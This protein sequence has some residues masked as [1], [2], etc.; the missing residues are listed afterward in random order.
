[1]LA[2][3]LLCEGGWEGL[4][5]GFP[6]SVVGVRKPLERWLFW[7]EAIGCDSVVLQRERRRISLVFLPAK[8]EDFAG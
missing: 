3:G 8:A 7:E 6:W 4:Y 1:M 5:E 2:E